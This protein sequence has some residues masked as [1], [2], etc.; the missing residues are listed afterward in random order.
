[1]SPHGTC[2]LRAAQER[3]LAAYNTRRVS[4][5]RGDGGFGEG[6]SAGGCGPCTALVVVDCTKPS[7]RLPD[8][9]LRRGGIDVATQRFPWGR[10]STTVFVGVPRTLAVVFKLAKPFFPRDMYERFRFVDTPA[11]LVRQHFVEA[12][13]LPR[14]LGGDAAWS[15]RTYVPQRCLFEG[16]L[17]KRATR[18]LLF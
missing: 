7:F 17:C 6:A 14:S 18:E 13:Q 11:D 16:A 9:A 5:A 12:S 4:D 10:R 3:I 2:T 15:L 1:L 8:L